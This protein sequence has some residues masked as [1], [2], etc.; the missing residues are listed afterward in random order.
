[1][2]TNQRLAQLWLL[3]DLAHESDLT[4]RDL[5][6]TGL[7]FAL[8][9]LT[10]GPLQVAWVRTESPGVEIVDDWD[11]VGQRTTGSGTVRSSNV[12]PGSSSPMS[13]RNGGY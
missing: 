11:A 9:A 13:R 3:L 2:R 12:A 4:I 6:A 1:M 7:P 8:A 5:E 10:D